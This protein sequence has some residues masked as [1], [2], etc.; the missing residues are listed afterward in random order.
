M[1]KILI[2]DDSSFQRRTI[3]R[4][5]AQADH[6]I[7]E[8]S[9]GAEAM[10]LIALHAPDCV[11]T[12]LIMPGTD[13]FAVLEALRDQHSHIPIIVI[14]ADIQSTTRQRC[15]ELGAVGFIQKPVDEAEVRAAVQRAVQAGDGLA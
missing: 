1:A 2:V 8:A 7:I 4:A 5:L 13:G 3:R 15:L 10:Q 12:D 6:E 9:D 11:L 14:T